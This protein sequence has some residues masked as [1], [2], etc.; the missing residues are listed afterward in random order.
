MS[1]AKDYFGDY[2]G[3]ESW[4]LEQIALAEAKSETKPIFYLQHHPINGF[5]TPEKVASYNSPEFFAELKNH[6]RVIVLNAH[7]HHVSED[8]RTISQDGFTTIKLPRLSG[9]NVSAQGGKYELETFDDYSSVAFLFDVTK[10]ADRNDEITI[11]RMDILSGKVIGNP[12]TF[13]AGDVSKY[14]QD[15]Y[16]MAKSIAS[17]GN[18]DALLVESSAQSR[19]VKVTFP[20]TNV[21]VEEAVI[22]LKEAIDAYKESDT[23]L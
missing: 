2:S 21:T 8:T 23:K 1:A 13:T 14:T 15:R 9:G 16:D 11:N 10:K 5:T 6:P 7:S 22:K 19:D 20:V 4:V 18:N 3:A 12:Y 17:F